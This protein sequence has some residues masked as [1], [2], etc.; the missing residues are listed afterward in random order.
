MAPP[1]DPDFSTRSWT[2]P[3]PHSAKGRFPRSAQPVGHMPTLP[4]SIQT[5]PGGETQ[6][7][8]EVCVWGGQLSHFSKGSSA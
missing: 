1:E 8:E 7:V 3:G 5:R 4:E 2:A 6:F